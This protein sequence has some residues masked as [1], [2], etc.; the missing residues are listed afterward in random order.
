MKQRKKI[1]KKSLIALLLGTFAVVSAPAV[2]YAQDGDLA[3]FG[4]TTVH[5]AQCPTPTKKY[6]KAA[7]DKDGEQSAADADDHT[8]AMIIAGVLAVLFAG[9]LLKRR[10]HRD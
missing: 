9:W 3:A 7:A 8:Q 1:L 10:F 6:Q 2:P 4:P 5:A